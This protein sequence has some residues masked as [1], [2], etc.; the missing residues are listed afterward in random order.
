MPH[1]LAGVSAGVLPTHSFDRITTGTQDSAGRGPEGG[2]VVNDVDDSRH[3]IHPLVSAPGLNPCI[4]S[5]MRFQVSFN[6]S[7]HS[8]KSAGIAQ[9]NANFLPLVPIN[10]AKR[11]LSFVPQN[12]HEPSEARGISYA[13][14]QRTRVTRRRTFGS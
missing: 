5:A 1:H 14:S 7:Y 12:N 4:S 11:K 3:E 9:S 6:S 10:I 8:P 2:V 13:R